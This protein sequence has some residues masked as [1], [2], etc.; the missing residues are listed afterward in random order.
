MVQAV[1]RQIIGQQRELV[2]EFPYFSMAGQQHFN[3]FVPRRGGGLW[4]NQHFFVYPFENVRIVAKFGFHVL[5][6]IVG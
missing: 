4:C 3:G 2:A 6:V 5:Y 1:V